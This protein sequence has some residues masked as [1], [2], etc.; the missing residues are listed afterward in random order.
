MGAP[1][2]R[3]FRIRN[4]EVRLDQWRR[5]VRGRQKTI[6]GEEETAGFRRTCGRERE[7]IQWGVDSWGGELGYDSKQDVA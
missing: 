2:V 3:G 7:Q 4:I 5:K 1:N 6:W